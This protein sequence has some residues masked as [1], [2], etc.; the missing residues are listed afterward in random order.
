MLRVIHNVNGHHAVDVVSTYCGAHS[1][2]KGST[3]AE[4]TKDIVEKQIP[5]L[6]EKLKAGEI[7]P[8]LIDVFCEKNVF[9]YDDTVKIVEAGKAIG[10]EVNF[11]GDEL[12][13]IKGGELRGQVGALAMSHCEETSDEG[14]LAMAK[15][16]TFA[17]LLP[18]TAYLLRLKYPRARK[19]IECNVPIALGSDFNPN[20]HCMSMPFVMNLACV[21]MG[22]TMPEALVRIQ[23]FV[24]GSVIFE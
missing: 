21:N 23:D 19:M 16:P 17:T 11:H 18:T 8:S 1:V 2:P 24:V 4:A 20:A 15:R 7:S 6:A 3:A 14:I 10:L 5:A 13:Y 12:S 9:E 22:M